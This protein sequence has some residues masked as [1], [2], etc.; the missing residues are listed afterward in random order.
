MGICPGRNTIAEL[1]SAFSEYQ[2]KETDNWR[3]HLRDLRGRT[4]L[5]AGW[6]ANKGIVLASARGLDSAPGFRIPAIIAQ[7]AQ[8]G[9]TS[10]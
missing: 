6:A 5:F 4:K 2:A 9:N 10:T 7:P 3:R 8:L 1:R